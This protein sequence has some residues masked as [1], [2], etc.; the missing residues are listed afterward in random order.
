MTGSG[1]A[2]MGS[3]QSDVPTVAAGGW[4]QEHWSM[5]GR[6]PESPHWF[7]AVHQPSM[8]KA[9]RPRRFGVEWI[10]RVQTAANPGF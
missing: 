7:T 5:D 3:G 6:E 8:Y 10:S 4:E 1:G 2:S 9:Q